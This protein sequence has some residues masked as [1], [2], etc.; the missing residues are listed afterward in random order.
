[1][2]Q[3]MTF[4]SEIRESWCYIPYPY[5]RDE[6]KGMCWEVLTKQAWFDR[7]LQ[8][9]KD[10]A[11]ARY[12]E[13]VESP[14]SGQLEYDGVDASATKPTKASIRVNDL[15][16][17]ITERYQ[18]LSSFSQKLQFLIDIHI[19]IFDQFH[20][21]LHSALEAYL[22]MTSAIGR[23]VQSSGEHANVEG[24]AGL[25]RLCRIFGSAEYLEKKMEDWS[26]D[27]FFVELWSELQTRLQ[28]NRDDRAN[29][30]G[31]M[32]VAD[33][34]SR[35]SSAV[36]NAQNLGNGVSVDGALFD[37]TASA[38]RRL[39]LRSETVIVSALCSDML[40]V[41]R[42]Y[43]RASAW[44]TLSG[45]LDGI[46]SGAAADSAS[47]FTPSSDLA[48]AVRTLSASASFLSHAI[49]TAPFR[50]IIRQLLR[51]VQSYIWDNVL[52]R[53]TF[54]ATGAAQFAGDV[55]HLCA[56]A[57]ASFATVAGNHGF[58]ERVFKKLNEGLLI[59]CLSAE[60]VSE[61]PVD[62]RKSE[63]GFTTSLGLWD[64]ERRVFKD[65]ESA[66]D[67]LSELG[68]DILTESE[69][70]MVLE[71]RIEIGS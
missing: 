68:I 51:Y 3:L 34:A 10:F 58:S 70:R 56:V 33:V 23:T 5:A 35:T 4:D 37:E 6:W 69:A 49:G 44:S 15:L 1:M 11:L 62:G 66:R 12:K 39:R 50:R 20:E 16:E 43:A 41:L 21:R 54:S 27:V 53:H 7:W 25:G 9:E 18:P 63:D 67:V 19:T 2:H 13:I 40:S 28:H 17:T 29:L 71:R 47:S 65:N 24:V 8:V 61:S 52:M 14:E 48:P 32:S 30:A 57:D 31:S 42:P 22:A 46:S 26:N 36:V 64:V 45:S 55:Y 60:S 38:Y 59:L